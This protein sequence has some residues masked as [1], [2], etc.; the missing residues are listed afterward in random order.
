MK[1]VL[2][3]LAQNAKAIVA[4]IA[5]VVALVGVDVPIDVQEA[6][7]AFLVALAVWLVPNKK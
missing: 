4:L 6:V 3:V 7:V 1:A 2:Q 5:T